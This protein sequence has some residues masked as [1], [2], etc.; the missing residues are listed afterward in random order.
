[1]RSVSPHFPYV[2]FAPAKGVRLLRESGYHNSVATEHTRSHSRD[3]LAHELAITEFDLAMWQTIQKTPNV[4]RL[5]VQRRYFRSEHQ[6]VFPESGR[7][8]RVIPDSGFML[9]VANANQ[10]S[11]D[12]TLLMHFTELDRGTMSVRRIRQ[13]L[14]RYAAWS[15]SESSHRYLKDLYASFAAHYQRPTFR[16]LIIVH[17]GGSPGSD[18]AR[19]VDI[20]IESLSLP[21]DLRK[22][23]WFTTGTTLRRHQHDERPLGVPIWL[24]PRDSGPWLSEYSRFRHRSAKLTGM[25]IRQLRRYVYRQLSCQPRRNL[26]PLA[27]AETGDRLPIMELPHGPA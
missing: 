13:K 11:A 25:P 21:P 23:I 18:E 16:L 19:L 1:V 8:I 12:P 6:L 22:R 17:V 27:G 4:H 14:Q 10:L 26:F 9:R 24:S 7:R 2:F 20:F 3:F 5:F 15:W